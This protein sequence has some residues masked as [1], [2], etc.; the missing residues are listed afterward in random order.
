MAKSGE[1]Q[2]YERPQERMERVGAQALGDAELLAMLVR[3]GTSGK[4]VMSVSKSLLRRAGSLN[5]MLNL[6][7]EDLCEIR[8]IGR[9]KSLQLL[10]VM[11]IA[12]RVL[13]RDLTEKPV[14]NEALAVFRYMQPIVVGLEV[15]KFWVLPLNRKHRLLR[16][17][18][19]TSGTANASLVHPREVYREAIRTAASAIICVHNHPSGDPAPSSADIRVTRQLRQSA[20]VLQIDLLDHIIVGESNADPQGKGYYSFSEAGMV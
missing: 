16:L 9:V 2:S 15:E 12:R 4:D 17:S 13:Q 3:S 11:E 6:R 8:G 10:A 20:E 1:D 19:V 18:E 7:A 14:L 5:G